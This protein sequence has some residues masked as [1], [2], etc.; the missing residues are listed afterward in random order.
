[1]GATS[2]RITGE[3]F[4]PVL[5]QARGGVIREADRAVRYMKGWSLE[6]VVALAER[7]GWKLDMSDDERAQLAEIKEAGPD[8]EMAVAGP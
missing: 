4:G 5:V 7:W 3:N 8:E 1:M 2:M 6:R